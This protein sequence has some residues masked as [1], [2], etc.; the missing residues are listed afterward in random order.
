MKVLLGSITFIAL[1]VV[2][3]KSDAAHDV[4]EKELDFIA[5][6]LSAHECRQLVEALHSD[7]MFL[8]E[9]PDGSHAPAN[10]S[11]IDMLNN[12]DQNESKQESFVRL[13]ERLRELGKKD[14]AAKV[15]RAVFK[16][17]NNQ[18]HL[19]IRHGLVSLSV[20]AVAVV[21]SL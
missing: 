16:V 5:H 7:Q 2:G 12:W 9:L 3:R 14:L 8:D 13:V 11:C 6:H 21:R 19:G 17:I 20:K 4:D 1:L 18:L 15:S 10:R